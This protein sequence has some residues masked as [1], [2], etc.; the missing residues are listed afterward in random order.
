[1]KNMILG[2]CIYLKLV[3]TYHVATSHASSL[4]KSNKLYIYEPIEFDKQNATVTV[5]NLKDGPISQL[6]SKTITMKDTPKSDTPQFLNLPRVL[7]SEISNQIWMIGGQNIL[8]KREEDSMDDSVWFG[9]FVNTPDIQYDTSFIEKPEF[10]HFPVGGFSQDIVYINNN[11]T[12]YIIGGFYYSPDKETKILT[13]GVFTYDFSS[14]NWHD[15]SES[16]SSILPPIADHKSVV[17]DNFIL[18][19]GGLSSSF[20]NTQYPRNSVYN[21][22]S[23]VINYFDKAY[24]YDLLSQKWSQVTIKTNL[25]E[26]LYK[27]GNTMSHMQ[28]A[29]LNLYK[30]SLV[31][32]TL[33]F[34]LNTE[35][36]DPRLGV[37]DYNNWEWNWYEVKT[38]SGGEN[39][40]KLGF[41]QAHV[42]KDQLILVHGKLVIIYRLLMLIFI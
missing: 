38:E 15:L 10:E 39:N 26:S 32:Y 22:T 25:N 33:L 27:S 36:F 3:Y 21:N 37:L 17:V 31:T 20:T 24:K 7:E 34:N 12:L 9:Q 6:E 16:A 40:L 29:S 1:M 35:S 18:V 19:T 13:S 28:G 42:I 30:G 41:C 5:Y 8:Y 2:F 14:N 11:P 23:A 4:L